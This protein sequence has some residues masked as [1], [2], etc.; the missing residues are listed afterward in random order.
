MKTWL[1]PMICLLAAA[2]AGKGEVQVLEHDGVRYQSLAVE[3]LPDLPK[4]LTGHVVLPL[5]DGFMVAGGHTTGFV[6]VQEAY[7]WRAGAW[8]TAPM[9]Y[10][11]DT[12]FALTMKDGRIVIGGGYSESFG[13]GQTWGVE[14]YDPATGKF[15]PEPIMN[16]K[17]A[18]ATAVELS[19][20][21]LIIS[22]NWY[23]ADATERYVFDDYDRESRPSSDT[24]SYPYVLRC[25]VD[26]AL[27]FGSRDGK[28]NLKDC[29]I[30]RRWDG[31]S[32]AVPLLKQWHPYSFINHGPVAG[33]GFIGDMSTGHF[34]YLIHAKAILEQHS[35]ILKVSGEIFSLLETESPIP[36]EG[37]WGR[38]EYNGYL[39]VDR[40]KKMA[41]L[42]GVDDERRVYLAAVDYEAAL[43]GT[44]AP[45]AMYFTEPLEDVGQ[46]PTS[47]LL[48]DGRMVIAGGISDSNYEPHAATYIFSVNPVPRRSALL[49]TLA[50]IIIIGACATL[51]A[52]RRRRRRVVEDP[53][54]T[55]R[56]TMAQRIESLMRDRQLFKRPNLRL[57]DVARELNTNTTYISA[58][59]NSETGLS[60]P[61]YVA[62][63]RVRYAQRLLCD[64]PDKPLPDVAA[65]SGFANEKSFY[66]TF[67]AHTGK[68]PGEWKNTHTEGFSDK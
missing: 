60:F 41:W 45:L 27:V 51:V 44:P 42:L 35:A 16:F 68:T 8:T 1:I 65:E 23:A 5:G 53:P 67:K 48:P 34:S 37:P 64:Y 3:R 28:Y 49:P 18:H 40:Q 30:V 26:N 61:D 36:S 12:P 11:H 43:G 38:I 22:G 63:F 56:M 50:G 24:L 55:E 21:K 57:A 9:L 7:I 25:D 17:R 2:C 31:D 19:G 66:R 54:T 52:V 4:P 6:P 33:E 47:R 46:S 15:S 62:S 29:S 39:Q 13:I 14:S 58:C 59:V 20:G 10:P 32:L